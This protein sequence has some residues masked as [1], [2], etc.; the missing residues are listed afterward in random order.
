M[1]VGDELWLESNRRWQRWILR[2]DRIAVPAGDLPID[3]ELHGAERGRYE[4][5]EGSENL[6]RFHLCFTGQAL[7]GE[8]ILK[9]IDADES[10]RSWSLAPAE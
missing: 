1:V 7:D 10:H 9:K 8:W 3:T 5:I 6:G 4:L 2:P